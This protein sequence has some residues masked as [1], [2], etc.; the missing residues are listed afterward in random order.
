MIGP[1]TGIA[2]FRAFLEERKITGAKGK[3]WLFFGDQCAATDFLYREQLQ[4]MLHEGHLTRLD[5]A[6]SRDQEQKIYVQQRMIENA[7]SFYEWLEL[8]AILYVCG[9]AKRMARDV[10]SAL[11]EIIS[12]AGRKTPAQAEEY[13]VNLK[14]QKRYQRD[15]Y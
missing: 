13:V 6:F 15:V 4:Q 2:P 8:G 5:T 14:A 3:T 12:Q 11:H 10:D 7:R 9:D 1:G